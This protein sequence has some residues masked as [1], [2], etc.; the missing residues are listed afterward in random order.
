MRIALVLG[1]R[2]QIIKSAPIVKEVRNWPDIELL[3]VHTG[4]HYDYTMSR[5]FFNELSLPDPVVNLGVGSGTHG[6]QTAQMLI[7]LEKTFTEIKPDLV[8]VPGDTNSTLAGCLA[9][10]KMHIPVAHVESGARSFD[11]D[12]PEEVNRVAVDHI[13]DVLLSASLN[14]VKNLKREGI[15][16][17]RV[18]LVGDTMYESI[19]NHIDEIRGRNA[20]QE[21][22][23]THSS[24]GVVTLHRAENTDDLH[25]LRNIIEAL[26]GLEMDLLFP[27][28]PRTKA[29]L[30]EL[31]LLGSLREDF[32]VIEPVP[33]FKIL[34]LI[35]DS[36]VVITD[37]G[38]VQKEAFWLGTPCVTLRETT[39]W[40]ETIEANANVLVGSDP[41]KIS[42]EV[43]HMA[44]RKK[45]IPHD[46]AG[47]LLISN[48]SR[49][50]LDIISRC[51]R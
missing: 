29:R 21:F 35:D 38:G 14:C 32:K 45:L 12:M 22:G 44:R 24:F 33:Y 4:Q 3:I 34:S 40:V 25:R 5:E 48:A 10:V 39:E 17:E 28:H 30:N 19:L 15:P 51:G 20:F 47:G 23:L 13:S 46:D 1:T 50:I 36:S 18:S 9:A 41:K 31:N 43:N 2:P 6:W 27:C 16:D 11:R 42:I 26:N 7:G 8:L 49:R 37:S